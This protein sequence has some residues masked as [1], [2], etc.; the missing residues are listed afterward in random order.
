[1]TIVCVIVFV[2]VCVEKKVFLLDSVCVQVL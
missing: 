2:I 1:M